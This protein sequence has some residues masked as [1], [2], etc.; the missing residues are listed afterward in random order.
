MIWFFLTT[1]ILFVALGV[2]F[3]A[4]PQKMLF[5]MPDADKHRLMNGRF[6]R[7]IAQ[8]GGILLIVLC[9][10]LNLI[11]GLL[12]PGILTLQ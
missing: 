2:V 3:L 7:V 5:L 6:Y 4:A 10:P 1:S 8:V 11:F 9:A 12:L